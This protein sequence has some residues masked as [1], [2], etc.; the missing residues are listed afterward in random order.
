MSTEN[1]QFPIPNSVLEPYIKQAVSGAIVGALGDGSKL[2]EAV[3]AQ[4]LS[5]KVSGDGKVSSYSSDNRYTFAE[6]IATNKIKEIAKEVI[7]QMAESM[8]PKIQ[9]QI[10]AQLKTK[11]KL[12]AQTLVD[13]MIKSLTSSWSVSIK[14]AGES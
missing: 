2:I 4:A 11:H 7:N 8:R 3:V 6:V 5:Q 12:I 14:M 13:G 10:E 9:A 1:M